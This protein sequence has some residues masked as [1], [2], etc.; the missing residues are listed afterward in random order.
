MVIAPS[1]HYI[2]DGTAL[3][4]TLRIAEIGA[5]HKGHI[6]TLG[7]IPNRIE[8]GFGYMLTSAQK[9]DGRNEP[10]QDRFLKVNRFIEKPPLEL[11]EK[12][13][14][15]E[16]TL[17]N[18]G[19]FL[20]RPST[21]ATLMSVHQPELWGALLDIQSISDNYR[22]LQPISIDYAILEKAESVYTV[23]AD[24][25]WDDVGSW[26]YLSR[27]QSSDSFDNIIQGDVITAYT[28]NCTVVSD[29]QTRV[30]GVS[31][32]IIVSTEH[33]LLVCHKDMEADIKK[34]MK[35]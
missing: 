21:I 17:W 24:F 16:G 26:G 5:R 11:A 31:D 29:R 27:T 25:R 1:D 32:L 33:G 13:I 9:E 3:A 19:I 2:S 22:K 23:P 8:A 4:D 18:S 12:L 20:W 10:I 14:G 28:T 6:V 35:P 30:V 34:H 15:Q 7:I